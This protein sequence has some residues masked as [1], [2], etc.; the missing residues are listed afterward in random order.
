MDHERPRKMVIM[1]HHHMLASYHHAF[2]M[3]PCDEFGV[4]WFLVPFEGIQCEKRATFCPGYFLGTVLQMKPC[5]RPYPNGPNL[6]GTC[7]LNAIQLH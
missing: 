2:L 4:G 3:E 7:R 6:I 5:P 1:G